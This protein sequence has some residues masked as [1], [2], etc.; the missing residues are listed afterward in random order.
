VSE[1]PINRTA[2]STQLSHLWRRLSHQ[3]H[4]RHSRLA[5]RDSSTDRYQEDCPDGISPAFSTP[6]KLVLRFPVLHFPVP[7]F[8]R[9][10]INERP[11]VE[12]TLSGT[13]MNV[14][15]CAGAMQWLD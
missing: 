6:A 1:T 2:D 8:Q 11:C 12:A 13:L 4:I 9:P 15:N 14:T 7:R 3:N 10:R 5:S